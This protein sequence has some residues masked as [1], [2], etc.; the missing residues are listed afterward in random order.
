MAALK[1]VRSCWS[2]RIIAGIII[3]TLLFAVSPTKAFGDRENRTVDFPESSV[4]IYAGSTLFET[5]VIQS[6]TAFPNGSVK[7]ILVGEGGWPDAL[8]ATGL[9]GLLD[10]PILFSQSSQMPACTMNELTRLNVKDIIVIGGPNVVSDSVLAQLEEM[11][12]LWSRVWGQSAY[13]TQ[14]AVFTEWFDQWDSD[15]AIVATGTDFVD[16]LS[17]SPIAFAKRAPVFLVDSTHN[18]SNGQKIALS[19]LATKGA[20][21]DVLLVGG[22]NVISDFTVGFLDGISTYA[23]GSLVHLWGDTLYDTSVAVANWSVKSRIL[24]WNNVAFASAGSPYDALS[25]AVLQAKSGSVL[26]LVGDNRSSTIEA[27]KANRN[28]ISRIRFFGGTS[29]I[30]ER[31]R[32]YVGYQLGIPASYIDLSMVCM[33]QYP[34][35]PTGCE[36][37]ALSNALTYYG[38]S[39][40]KYEIADR[41]LPRSSWDWVT[42]YQGNPYSW[43][44]GSWN[45]CC[46]PAICVAAN[47]YL[48]AH[49]SSLRAYNVT[50]TSFNDLYNYVSQGYPVI[51]WNTIDMRL[52]GLS[53]ETRWCDG[54]PY[55]LY[56]GT[57]T[58]VLKG[59]DKSNGT[60]FIADSISGYV[61]RNAGS[62]GWVYS[63][64]GSQ[65]VVIK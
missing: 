3:L 38:F 16:A 30:S 9:A 10:C 52:P 62:F 13:D 48:V 46:A 51:V 18:L 54:V 26:L 28:L 65:A 15:L 29:V 36:A 33:M 37:V 35:L 60:V 2:L 63:M 59:F 41:W 6:S 20:L 43:G 31:L 50:G 56:D 24:S 39:L 17:T 42:A 5:A 23:G 25:G 7:A 32:M 49:G 27:A 64:V 47:D 34:E 22:R 14:M 58:V 45:S 44:G 19:R 11:G 61:S 12:I 40:S 57:H 1:G 8:S 53:T 21:R 55:R 4:S